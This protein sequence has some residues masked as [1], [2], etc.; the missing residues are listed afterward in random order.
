VVEKIQI[1]IPLNEIKETQQNNW[2]YIPNFDYK[3]FLL[4]D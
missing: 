1:I 4:L 2:R 3:R